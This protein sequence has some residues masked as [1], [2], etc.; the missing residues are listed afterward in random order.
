MMSVNATKE[1]DNRGANVHGVC[2]NGA[3]MNDIHGNGVQ[4]NGMDGIDSHGFDANGGMT[5][6]ARTPAC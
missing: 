5:A 2:G 1:G 6:Y 4:V 3:N